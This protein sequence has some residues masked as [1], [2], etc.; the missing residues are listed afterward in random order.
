[1]KMSAKRVVLLMGLGL[2]LLLDANLLGAPPDDTATAVVTIDVAQIMEWLADFSAIDLED[3]TTQTSAPT[4]SGT[5]TLYTNGDV[6]I[7]ANNTAAAQLKLGTDPN[8]T[9]VTSYKLT[10]DGGSDD[11]GGTGGTDQGSYTVHSSFLSPAY[12]ITHVAGD[13]AVVIELHVE[14]RNE[15]GDVADVGPYSATQTLTAAWG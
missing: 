6:S 12:V 2:A 10:D 4:G 7:T 11:G 14:A 13:G 5:A 1:M 9:L 15:D 3:I 8:Q